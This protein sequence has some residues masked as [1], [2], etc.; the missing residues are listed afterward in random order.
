MSVF[1]DIREA[2]L[3]GSYVHKGGQSPFAAPDFNPGVRLRDIS[4]K[5]F[6]VNT[7]KLQAQDNFLSIAIDENGWAELTL[8]G[9]ERIYL[10]ADTWQVIGPRLLSYLRTGDVSGRA[11]DSR[12]N[13]YPVACL[14]T[15]SEAHHTLYVAQSGSDGLLFWQDAGSPALPITAMRLSPE[16]CAQWQESLA[17]S[18]APAKTLV[19]SGR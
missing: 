6:V 17:A 10:G 18:L 1:A 8:T 7:L 15:L 13:G 5:S 11:Y 9:P 12:I 16:R 3:I 14:L 2:S 4:E 19:L